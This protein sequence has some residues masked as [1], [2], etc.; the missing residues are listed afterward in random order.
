MLEGFMLLFHRDGSISA[1]SLCACRK[2]QDKLD[3]LNEMK[4]CKKHINAKILCETEV[5]FTNKDYSFVWS[6]AM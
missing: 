2:P 5:K 3:K 6:D 1:W 4:F